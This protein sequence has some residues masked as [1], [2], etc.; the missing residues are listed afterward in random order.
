[1]KIQYRFHPNDYALGENEKFYSDMEKK[2]W[3]LEKRGGYLSKF[4]RCDPSPA[5]YRIE[6]AAPGFLEES[7]LS[8]E[9]VMVY[10]D[11]G[12][13]YVAH[14]GLLH[15]FRAPAGSDAPEF[16]TDPRQQAATLKKLRRQYLLAWLPLVIVVGLNFTL[17]A[18]LTGGSGEVV[19]EGMAK[20]R[21]GWVTLTAYQIGFAAFLLYELYQMV[22]GAVYI[23]R[24][25]H[26]MKKGVPLDHAPRGRHL[27]HR[28]L[29]WATAALVALCAVLTVWQFI[30]YEKYELPM[31]P[32]GPYV[33][34]SDLG[35]EGERGY[36][37]YRD[38]D[39]H[40]EHARSLLAEFWLTEE[41]LDLPGGNQVWLDQDVY[42]LRREDMAEEFAHTLMECA[43]FADYEYFE[44][45]E[46]PGLD[47]VR[48]SH[49]EVVA[50]K[51][52][53]VV[54]AVF[55]SAISDRGEMRESLLACLAE[56]WK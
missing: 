7:F 44:P 19:R 38:H 37:F 5:R 26:R 53:R 11:C 47:G 32:D 40:V 52:S 35:F 6:V 48:A 8:D 36:L 42:L 29:G 22:R 9:Q 17:N 56:S 20:L 45:V 14:S 16:Y 10:E 12:W 33:M 24:T 25:Y 31:E 30:D 55:S 23:S 27:L 43:I 28:L 39:S 46:F 51:G 41:V 15:V 3:K 34:L 2:G 54:Y 50:W 4:R 13:E 1:M 49:M 21:H 18:A